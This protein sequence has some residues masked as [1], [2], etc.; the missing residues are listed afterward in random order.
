MQGRLEP[1]SSIFQVCRCPKR[2]CCVTLFYGAPTG[3]EA[4]FLVRVYRKDCR[5]GVSHDCF[6]LLLRGSVMTQR[7]ESMSVAAASPCNQ[8]L[9]PLTWN[10]INFQIACDE[11]MARILRIF[12]TPNLDASR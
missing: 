6:L 7:W 9:P 3:P 1:P 12:P 11:G 8:H 4:R 2:Q 5:F 10:Q